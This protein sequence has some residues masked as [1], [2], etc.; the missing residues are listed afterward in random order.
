[1]SSAVVAPTLTGF[2]SDV[3][4]SKE[5]SFVISACLVVTGTLIFAVVTL[6]KKKATQRIASA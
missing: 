2:I 6:Y 1:M 5:I 4:G 3:T